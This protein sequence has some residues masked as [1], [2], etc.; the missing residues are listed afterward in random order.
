MSGL[1][2][3]YIRGEGILFK[4]ARGT[5]DRSGKEFHVYHEIILFLDG[6]GEFIS[7]NLHMQ[8]SGGTLILIPRETYHQLVIHGDQERYYRCVLQFDDPEEF[9]GLTEAFS[10][11]VLTLEAD[12]ELRYLFD[13]LI[14][15]SKGEQ[16]RA[17]RILRSVL[18][19][20]LDAVIPKLAAPREES[21]QNPVIQLAV[22]YINRNLAEQLSIGQIARACNVSASTLSHIFKGEM[23]TS[24]H[25]FIVNKR[26]ISA[27]H[28]ISSGESATAA[29][30]ACGFGDYSGFYKQYKRVFGFPPS[31]GNS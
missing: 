9:S 21:S 7:E 15:A 14:N 12:Q 13:K 11:N 5:S 31:R 27:Y 20:L 2:S 3:D 28:R 22:A 30:A 18:V 4:H 24:V 25:R 29:A 19:L 6:D 8:L 10:Q 1:F 17:L 23:H 16:D 26:L